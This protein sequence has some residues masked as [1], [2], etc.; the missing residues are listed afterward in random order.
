MS[1]TPTPVN[2][3]LAGRVQLRSG[4]H[5]GYL[6]GNFGDGNHCEKVHGTQKEDFA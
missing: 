3:A 1:G 5:Y 6:Q 4:M 2:N